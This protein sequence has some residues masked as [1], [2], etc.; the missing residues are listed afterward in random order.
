M[1]IAYYHEHSFSHKSGVF[2]KLVSQV[3]QWAKYGHEVAVFNLSQHD[4]YSDWKAVLSPT[5]DLFQTVWPSRLARFWLM[6]GVIRSMLNWQPDIIYRR[7]GP[8]YPSFERVFGLHPMVIEVNGNV[9]KQTQLNSPR[10][11]WYGWLTQGRILR[12]VAGAVFVSYE[13][14][15]QEQFA[16]LKSPRCVIANGI[17]LGR[18]ETSP[19]PSNRHPRLVFM[20]AD[21]FLWNGTEK[22]VWLAQQFPDWHFD[23]IGLT[24]SEPLPP[25]IKAHGLM[26]REEYQPLM[27]QADVAIGTLSLYERDLC[28]NSALRTLEY[29]AY[30]LPII[31]GHQEVNFMEPVDFI[32]ELPCTETNVIDNVEAIERFVLEHKGRR[33]PRDQIQHID[34]QHKERERLN[35][36]ESILSN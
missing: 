35:F 26:T 10:R 2:K 7:H 31:L 20:A 8:Y 30:G 29:V 21:D 23:I 33:V 15:G 28:Q 5:V 3:N 24:L 9:L 14:A 6:D 1:R 34:V 25:N 4:T 11:Y 18:F 17:D 19:A 12:Q 13:L 27:L 22:V 36:F 32:L 16:A